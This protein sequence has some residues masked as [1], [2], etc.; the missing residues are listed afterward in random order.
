MRH[1]VRQ[2]FSGSGDLLG[3]PPRRKRP[4]NA[5]DLARCDIAIG[6]SPQGVTRTRHRANIPEDAIPR[7]TVPQ[8]LSYSGSLV[9]LLSE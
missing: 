4:D 3:S 9:V 8:R 5:K 2:P 1:T 6:L 7:L